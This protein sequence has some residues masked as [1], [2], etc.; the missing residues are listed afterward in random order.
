MALMRMMLEMVNPEG[1]RGGKQVRQIGADRDEL[2]QDSGAKD[3]IMGGIV[4]DH[5]SAMVRER[6]ER[7][8]EKKADPPAI[9]TE[10]TQPEGD[11]ALN[12]NH[13]QRDQRRRWIAAHQ[14]TDFRMRPED[15]ARSFGMRLVNVGLVEGLLHR[16][17]QRLTGRGPKYQ[18]VLYWA[19][20]EKATEWEAR[21]AGLLDREQSANDAAHDEGHVRRVVAN[22]KK[23]AEA[24][25]ADLAVVLP[26]AWLHDCIAI[27][28]N[29]P[30]R[31]SASRL[32]AERAGELLRAAGYP[33]Q[34]IPAIEHAIEA[35][36]FSARVTPRTLEA[37]VV[38]DADRLE[39]LGAVGIARTLI[40]GGAN[41]T[42]FYNF[43]EPFPVT[44]AADDRTSIIDHFFTKLLLLAETMQ[45]AAGRAAAQQRAE[46]LKEFLT[47]LGNEIGVPFR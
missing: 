15:R 23:L 36:S 21:F 40:T 43:S 2:V 1:T 44:R 42:P 9:G 26:A 32:A 7:V 3:E 47:Q 18:L 20:I 19:M 14:R 22:A 4:D 37:K 29:S 46:F 41:G 28:K 31:T 16:E 11:R 27:A 17:S 25:A 6:A 10:A 13:Q 34:H 8:G 35:H 30:E 39:A 38:Q 5:V 45:T 12:R 24:E 33:A